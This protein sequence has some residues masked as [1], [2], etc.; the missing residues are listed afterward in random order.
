M[1]RRRHGLLDALDK[2]I[3]LHSAVAAETTEILKKACEFL[4]LA[5]V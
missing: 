1:M 3:A 2:C 5:L 4:L